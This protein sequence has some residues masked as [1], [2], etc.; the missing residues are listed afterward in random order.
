MF[1]LPLLF[2]GIYFGF[3]T[4]SS[5]HGIEFIQIP[6]IYYNNYAVLKVPS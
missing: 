5:V 2:C 1:L 4:N 6:M 3:I